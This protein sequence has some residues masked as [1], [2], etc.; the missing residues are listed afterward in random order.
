MSAF[1]I[2]RDFDIL[3]KLLIYFKSIF[4]KRASGF[5]GPFLPVSVFRWFDKLKLLNYL[6]S[7]KLNLLLFAQERL[8]KIC[9]STALTVF[10]SMTTDDWNSHFKPHLRARKAT[11]ASLT[12]MTSSHTI[13]RFLSST[14]KN[15]EN[16]LCLWDLDGTKNSGFLGQVIRHP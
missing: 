1:C 13:S 3:S 4:L 10:K 6:V 16:L 9:Q 7:T 5:N 12:F 11:K 15:G 14:S 8:C 2:Y